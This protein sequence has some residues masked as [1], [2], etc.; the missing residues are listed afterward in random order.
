MLLPLLLTLVA[1]AAKSRVGSRMLQLCGGGS[2]G[3][4]RE[5]QLQQRGRAAADMV[6][7][8]RACVRPACT[9]VQPAA[10]KSGQ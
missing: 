5:Q 10:V 1:K 2:E 8:E 7:I 3:S 4:R 6:F 9:A